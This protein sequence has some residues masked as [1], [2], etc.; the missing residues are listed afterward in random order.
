MHRPPPSLWW[1]LLLALVGAGLESGCARTAPLDQTVDA[2]SPIAL[3]MWR[4]RVGNDLSRAQWQEFDHSVQEIKFRIMADY[5]ATGA[6]A[7]D[8]SLREKIDGQ[9][10]RQVLEM[11]C[12]AT[13][14]RLQ[15]DRE[16]VEHFMSVNATLRTRPNDEASIA[17]LR[18]VHESQ[19][20]QLKQITGQIAAG[21][22]HLR[23]LQ[24]RAGR[25][26][27]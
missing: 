27:P 16:Q 21:E 17:Y 20:T 12:R 8:E 1:L 15:G 2:H 7:V 10:V 6:L 22:A 25:A 4:S 11:G 18:G 24:R 9:T 14:S 13:L 23:E 26:S 3:A 19:V 5:V